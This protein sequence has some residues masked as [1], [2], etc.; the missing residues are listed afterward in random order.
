MRDLQK[1]LNGARKA[2]HRVKRIL[3][4][5]EQK[6]QMWVT[7]E[8]ELRA[9]YAQE[10]KRHVK[11][12]KD[13]DAQ[14]QEALEQQDDARAQVRRVAANDEAQETKEPETMELD[15]DDGFEQML[16]ADKSPDPW[17]DYAN[18][19]VLKRAL[20]SAAAKVPVTPPPARPMPRTSPQQAVGKPQ[21]TASLRQ[22][23]PL[24]WRSQHPLLALA[25]DLSL[26]LQSRAPPLHP[27]LCRP[28]PCLARQLQ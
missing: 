17:E 13:L 27:K 21:S 2:E 4:D 16:N 22:L 10:K 15:E 24:V 12:L 26:R 25:C 6:E 1:A 3:Q 9:T 11:N 5:K 18:E 28:H 20:M 14:L 19:E 7:W 8:K 23:H